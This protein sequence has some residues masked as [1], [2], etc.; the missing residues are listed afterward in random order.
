MTGIL[1]KELHDE[2]R[3]RE[4]VDAYGFHWAWC[5]D[6]WM[7]HNPEAVIDLVDGFATRCPGGKWVK[8]DSPEVVNHIRLG[9]DYGP[10]PFM[11]AV[12]HRAVYGRWER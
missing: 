6:T 3:D 1:V 10:G 5:E 4:W 9:F 8:P 2:H 7:W 12:H 11:E